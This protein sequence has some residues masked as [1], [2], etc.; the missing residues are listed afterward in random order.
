MS[1][2]RDSS[3]SRGSTRIPPVKGQKVTERARKPWAMLCAAIP[4]SGGASAFSYPTSLA[5]VESGF[6]LVNSQF[7]KPRTGSVLSPEE[8]ALRC[9][10]KSLLRG[11]QGVPSTSAARDRPQGISGAV[12]VF[13]R[14]DLRRV[15]AE[16]ADRTAT[17][18]PCQWVTHRTNSP[19]SRVHLES[20]SDGTECLRSAVPRRREAGSRCATELATVSASAIHRPWG[21]E[22][23]PP[24]VE[25]A[26]DP[27]ALDTNKL[28][29]AHFRRRCD[30]HWE[31]R[32]F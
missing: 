22:A 5:G 23:S 25:S 27:P 26:G 29:T 21:H 13:G 24:L 28:K 18:Q 14:P 10:G 30:D 12:Q 32:Q 4:E 17:Q 15:T 20:G 16:S 2:E 9:I 3:S 7:S 8:F 6:G 11:Q 19:I 31:R 1:L